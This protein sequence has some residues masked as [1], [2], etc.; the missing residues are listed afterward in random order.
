MIHD[1]PQYSL[2][3]LCGQEDVRIGRIKPWGRHTCTTQGVPEQ[4]VLLQQFKFSCADHEIS[5]KGPSLLLLL[6]IAT[7]WQ[8]GSSCTLPGT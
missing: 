7:C 4:A 2:L 6:A 3:L 5:P 8:E 1:D